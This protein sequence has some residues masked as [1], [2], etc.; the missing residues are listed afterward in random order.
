MA[1]RRHH[2]DVPTTVHQLLR[3]TSTQGVCLGQGIHNPTSKN[4]QLV[5]IHYRRCLAVAMAPTARFRGWDVVGVAVASTPTSTILGVS[6]CLKERCASIFLCL[7]V[8]AAHRAAR[9][10]SM[11]ARLRI[12]RI[13]SPGEQHGTLNELKARSNVRSWRNTGLGAGTVIQ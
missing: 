2:K 8:W 1:L 12:D 13:D 4:K 11:H 6:R 9:K 3:N 5:P 10:I 7:M